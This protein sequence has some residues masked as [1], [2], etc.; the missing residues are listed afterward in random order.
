[1]KNS[2]GRRLCMTR[3][4]IRKSDDLSIREKCAEVVE[5]DSTIQIEK[6]STPAPKGQIS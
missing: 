6:D 3:I 2:W 1:M 4:L 5:V